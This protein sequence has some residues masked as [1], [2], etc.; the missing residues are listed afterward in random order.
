MFIFTLFGGNDTIK[1]KPQ[2][3]TYVKR[4]HV[5]FHGCSHNKMLNR[6]NILEGTFVILYAP[7]AV[8]FIGFCVTS[9]LKIQCSPC[10]TGDTLVF[11]ITFGLYVS[12]PC[13]A[14]V[15]GFMIINWLYLKL[16]NYKKPV[17]D[18]VNTI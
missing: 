18:I 8:L 5:V 14:A 7:A 10:G 11:Y 16:R 6:F 9:F 4:P 1:K 12:L 2:D 15:V 13:A 3:I 17:L